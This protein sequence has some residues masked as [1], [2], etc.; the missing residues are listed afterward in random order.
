MRRELATHLQLP[1]LLWDIEIH[2]KSD[3][4]STNTERATRKR[5]A[6]SL[7]QASTQCAQ[8]PTLFYVS[9][10]SYAYIVDFKADGARAMHWPMPKSQNATA[11]QRVQQ[12]RLSL[13]AS[14]ARLSSLA[15]YQSKEWPGIITAIPIGW[16]RLCSKDGCWYT[17]V[18]ISH[19]HD[20]REDWAQP[21]RS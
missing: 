8:D 6:G 13:L 19:D 1:D 18:M 11:I 7:K 12:R 9:H 10:L 21:L 3:T 2:G 5:E 20:K 4:V 15:P 16:R 17:T 14:R